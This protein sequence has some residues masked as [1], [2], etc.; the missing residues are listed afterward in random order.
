M[1]LRPFVR[2]LAIAIIAAVSFSIYMQRKNAI[3]GGQV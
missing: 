2:I 1:R 3:E